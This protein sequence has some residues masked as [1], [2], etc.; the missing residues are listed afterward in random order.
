MTYSQTG[1]Q[2]EVV[3]RTLGNL[4]RSICGDRSRACDQALPQ[5]KFAYYRII[6]SSM[7]MS[8]FCIVYRHVPHHLLDLAKLSTGEKFSNTAS[9][10]AEQAID[11]Q[12]EVRTRLEKFNARYK[13]AADKR[14][15]VN[16]FEG[17]MV[18]VYLRKERIPVEMY[19][20]LKPKNDSFQIV[21]N[22]NDNAYVVD[23]QSDMTISRT[24]NVADLYD[25]H[26]P[27]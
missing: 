5:P 3:N 14:R 17:D 24:F 27:E 23:L 9:A 1:R 15:K 13:A 4:L 22:I 18:M 7:G 11:V 21:R 12:K 10:M 2:T 26:P 16:V 8:P 25:Y 19:N 20:K 6:Y